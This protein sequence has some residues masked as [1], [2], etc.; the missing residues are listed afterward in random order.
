LI[1]SP[2]NPRVKALVRLR[3]RRERDRTDTALCE[4]LQ[5]TRRALTSGVTVQ[6]L[7]L[8]P[9]HLPAGADDLLALAE[10]RSVPVWNL[11]ASVFKRISLRQHPDGVA[12]TFTPP[13][14]T[15]SSLA[16]RAEGLL[17]VAVG[18]E[19]P[20]NLGA[21]VRSADALGAVGVVAVT[22]SGSD[23][24]N[25]AAVRASMGSVF[26]LPVAVGPAEAV[27]TA[28]TSHGWRTV[29][30]SPAG[31]VHPWQ[32]DWSK[33]VALVVGP[34]HEGLDDAWLAAADTVVGIPMEGG[35]DSMN[36]S[37]SGAIL[38]Y[39]ALRSRQQGHA[40]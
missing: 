37:V 21:L 25:A 26:T 5:E 17:L 7:W 22:G 38:L 13:T 1:E 34:E 27:R 11:T 15:A 30:S 14:V 39:E 31:G 24:W 6:A 10:T 32:V 40:G 29:A 28:L 36:A 20:G 35:A 3:Q 12:C 23:P 16:D 18:T 33:R 19:K 4:G 9:E 2:Q 8:C